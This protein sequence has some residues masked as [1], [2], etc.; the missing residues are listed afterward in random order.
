MQT[1]HKPPPT[2]RA[3]NGTS[4]LNDN[5]QLQK[6]QPEHGMANDDVQDDNAPLI[7]S[8][9]AEEESRDGS[10]AENQ[11]TGKPV[12]T[13]VWALTLTASVSGLLFGYE[14]VSTGKFFKGLS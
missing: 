12:T 1:C 9:L 13:F 8:D 5:I 11:Q 6:L 4:S 3:Q 14:W 10:G 2:P 7:G